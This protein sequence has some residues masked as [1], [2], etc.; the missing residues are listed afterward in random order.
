MCEHKTNFSHEITLV[1]GKLFLIHM[2][3]LDLIKK[4]QFLPPG[5]M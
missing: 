1:S 5:F 2:Y 4:V 3:L